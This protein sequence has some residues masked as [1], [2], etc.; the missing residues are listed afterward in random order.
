MLTL[1]GICL[2][3]GARAVLSDALRNWCALD[4]SLKLWH[5]EG[6]DGTLVSV[7]EATNV[8]ARAP[9]HP[10]AL[11]G[12]SL[13]STVEISSRTKSQKNTEKVAGEAGW[14]PACAVHS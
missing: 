13:P 14:D 6:W 11:T 1:L 9:S 3:L 4:P 7:S 12:K 10:D 5:L 8:Q 2:G